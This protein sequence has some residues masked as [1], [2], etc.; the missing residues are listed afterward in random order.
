M[1]VLTSKDENFVCLGCSM[2]SSA[3]WNLE[4]ICKSE[5]FENVFVFEKFSNVYV[6]QIGREAIL[7]AIRKLSRSKFH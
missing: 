4:E 5:C 3:I 6:F 2:V 7:H 1:Y